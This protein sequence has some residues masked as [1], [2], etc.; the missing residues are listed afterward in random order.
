MKKANDDEY[1][2]LVNCDKTRLRLKT[3]KAPSSNT[4]TVK[5]QAIKQ[6]TEWRD[7]S[8]ATTT[9]QKLILVANLYLELTRVWARIDKWP[10]L[11]GRYLQCRAILSCITLCCDND[12]IEFLDRWGNPFTHSAFFKESCPAGDK[13]GQMCGSGNKCRR[14]LN[15]P[16]G[17]KIGTLPS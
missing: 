9:L 17:P 8:H 5:H 7:L 14:L 13:S 10:E 4:L 16:D 15:R 6:V 3:G 12:L 11:S 2:V 1:L